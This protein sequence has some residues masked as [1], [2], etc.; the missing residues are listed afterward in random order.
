MVMACFD[1]SWPILNLGVAY[2]HS[3]SFLKK[4]GQSSGVLMAGPA[5]E[6]SP[7]IRCVIPATTCASPRHASRKGTASMS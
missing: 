7:I 2:F 4:V 6:H 3:S 5:H 1:P